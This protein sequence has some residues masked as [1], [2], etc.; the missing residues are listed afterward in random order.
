MKRKQ[1]NNTSLWFISC[2]FEFHY[3][4]SFVYFRMGSYTCWPCVV[5]TLESLNN[6]MCKIE[7][8]FPN[9]GEISVRTFSISANLLFQMDGQVTRTLWWYAYNSQNRTLT[10]C[11]WQRACVRLAMT[12][13]DAVRNNRM[14]SRWRAHVAEHVWCH[15]LLCDNNSQ[16]C[17]CVAHIRYYGIIIVLRR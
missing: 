12:M 2:F 8:N 14:C 6:K 11:I 13:G 3:A 17:V 4:V 10:P 7:A 15:N 5:S 9:D 16:M 1:R